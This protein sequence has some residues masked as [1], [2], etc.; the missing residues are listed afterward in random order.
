M[1]ISNGDFETGSFTDW[2]Y[3]A[4]GSG[5]YTATATVTAGAKRSGTYGARLYVSTYDSGV[6]NI[7]VYAY[8]SLAFESLEFWRKVNAADTEYTGGNS[9]TV[10]VTYLV[11]A[12]TTELEIL[13][14]SDITAGDWVYFS[15]SKAEME[16]MFDVGGVWDE[17]TKLR[18]FLT[19]TNAE[20]PPKSAELFIDDVDSILIDFEAPVGTTIHNHVVAP[21]A[22]WVLGDVPVGAI[23]STPGTPAI[24][25]VM[26][27]GTSTIHNHSPVIM[28]AMTSVI[29]T[30]TVYNTPAVSS[31]QSLLILGDTYPIPL[32]VAAGFLISGRV[33]VSIQDKM[34][35]GTFDFETAAEAYL[36]AMAFKSA[37]FII[38]DIN[39]I[40][41]TVLYGIFP[42]SSA[43]LASADN[44]CSLTAYD[45][46]WYLTMQYLSDAD[47]VLL[48][49]DD[50]AATFQYRLNYDYCTDPYLNFAEGQIVVGSITGHSGKVIENHFSGA[51]G[52]GW[53][54]LGDM[55]G[56]MIA[57]HYFQD[58]ENLQVDGVTYAAANG[59]T[60][61]YTSLWD[62]I[63]PDDWVKRV[64]GGDNWEK[65]T[66]IYPYRIATVP[67]WNTLQVTIPFNE[68][69][70]KMQAIEQVAKY[71][72]YIFVVKWRLV[73]ATYMPLAYFIPQDE[74]DYLI[75]NGDLHNGLDLPS[76]DPL[77]IVTL[78]PDDFVSPATFE[79][80]GEEKY[81]RVNV[82][83][84]SLNGIWYSSKLETDGVKYG[85]E[86]PVEFYEINTEIASQ[87]ECDA[88]CLDLYTY[89][90][91]HIKKWEIT[92]LKRSDLQ[93]YQKI[94][95]GAFGTEIPSGNYRII[96]IE[97]T[98][99]NG[100]I[101]N[102]TKCA[103]VLDDQFHAYL[104]ISRTFTDTV[105]EMRA[106]AKD[107][108]NRLGAI[109]AGTVTAIDGSKVTV[110]TER[111][112]TK[113][114]RD[115]AA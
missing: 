42:S 29:P 43:Q 36:T 85:D 86:I 95:L 110:Q 54:L 112:L 84:Q 7:D 47:M 59:Y 40:P 115:P 104:N 106:I 65:V 52:I 103:I 41:Q 38:P 20:S 72:G 91:V 18:F 10:T 15:I 71:I 19:L 44:K 21:L 80:K 32:S 77:D 55:D 27:G 67:N 105:S 53:L 24:L 17:D 90:A 25:D 97:Y 62:D 63:Y 74:I 2:N 23:T 89:Y 50:Q 51:Y 99:A 28:T 35:R 111:G 39:N 78:T 88:R 13:Y 101:E 66:G 58:D 82:R 107:E 114:T 109:E 113:I 68:K 100:G 33:N 4:T 49:L 14:N 94:N 6:A 108:I 75:A 56:T 8:I 76:S 37:L 22:A 64:L 30:I 34:F 12:V 16:A 93:L 69:T 92:L 83:C 61:D 11:D 98:Y 70:T 9:L 1:T 31:L 26:D 45:Y 96:S 102:T 73:G 57:G 48:S 81:S 79:E 3:Q 60:M 5:A 87:A 46:A